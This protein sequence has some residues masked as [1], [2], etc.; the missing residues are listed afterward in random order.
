MI[1]KSQSPE[2]TIPEVSITDYV[3]R[4]ADR[5]GDKPALVD[6]PTGRTLTYRQLRTA[7]DAWRRAWR[8]G[9]SRRATSSRSTAPT[10]RNTVSPC[11]EPPPWAPSSP[12]PIRCTRPTS[13][14]SSSWTRGPAPRDGA[15]LPRQGEGS[16]GEGRRHRGHLRVRRW[17]RARGPSRS[18]CSTGTMPPAVAI[19]PRNDIVV[20]P[21]SSGTTGLPKGVMLTHFNLVANLCQAEGMRNFDGF[22]ERGRHHGGAALLSHLRHGRDHDAGARQGR[23]RRRR[24]RASTSR[25]S[26]SSS[27]ST[28]SRSCRWCRPSCSVW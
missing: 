12:P 15:A 13:L 16:G 19:D 10:C 14:P 21:Y 17:L 20:L 28:G 4:H 22:G 11:W 18:S 27:R 8:S 23:H 24:C 7:F 1:V 26:S 25:N 3:L 2:V 9:A 5:L 6:G